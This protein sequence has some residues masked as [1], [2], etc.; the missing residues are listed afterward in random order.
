MPAFQ[1]YK[2]RL[3]R[4]RAQE[5]A[6]FCGED[7]YSSP[8]DTLLNG[9][10]LH[11]QW[12][13]FDALC[14]G[15][16]G[17]TPAAQWCKVRLCHMETQES[18]VFCGRYIRSHWQ[19]GDILLDGRLLHNRL[20]GFDA[21]CGRLLGLMPASQRYIVRLC[22]IRTQDIALLCGGCIKYQASDL[23][24]NSRILHDRGTDS[25][26]LCGRLLAMTQAS[27]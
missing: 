4:I 12:T 3:C 23:L 17:S 7:L 1:Q 22:R 18:T 14:G 9:G 21:L 2:V 13:D 10:L 19:G 20:T 15:L 24:L 5:I 11:S 16:L 8:G 6:G 25:D 26:A 27:Q